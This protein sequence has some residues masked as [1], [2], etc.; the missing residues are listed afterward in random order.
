MI[1]INFIYLYENVTL[2]IYVAA[3]SAVMAAA[4]LLFITR[5]TGLFI[6]FAAFFAIG[7]GLQLFTNGI[8]SAYPE[9]YN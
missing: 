8:R 6:M 3:K 9:L 2:M 4:I 1:K 5:S 7:S